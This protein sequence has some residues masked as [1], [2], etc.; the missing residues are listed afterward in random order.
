MCA[1]RG[2]FVTSVASPVLRSIVSMSFLS[3]STQSRSP[4]CATA[5]GARP[6]SRSMCTKSSATRFASSIGFGDEL[7]GTTLGLADGAAGDVVADGD[8]VG[9]GDAAEMVGLGS[10][11]ELPVGDAAA[12]TACGTSAHVSSP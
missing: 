11:G 12:I 4:L 1:L 2:R 5:Y 8:V 10:L 6:L 7:A 3:S 9:D